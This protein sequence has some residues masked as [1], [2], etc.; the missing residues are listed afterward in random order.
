MPRDIVADGGMD[1]LLGYEEVEVVSDVFRNHLGVWE[2]LLRRGVSQGWDHDAAVAG[3]DRCLEVLEAVVV[4]EGVVALVA[5]RV[6][7]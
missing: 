3:G 1:L 5:E 7:F 6:S 4:K 2:V